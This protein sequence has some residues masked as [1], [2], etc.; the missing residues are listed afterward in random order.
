MADV[1]GMAA[2][3]TAQAQANTQQQVETTMLRKELDM[4]KSNAS[5]LL[6]GIPEAGPSDP[7]AGAANPSENVGS[8]VNVSA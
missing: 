8:T 5:Q 2:S 7:A 4:Q 6:E 1:S 3:S